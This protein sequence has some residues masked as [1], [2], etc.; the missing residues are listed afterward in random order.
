MAKKMGFSH[1]Q[2]EVLEADLRAM[3]TR[4]Q[5]LLIESSRGYGVSAELT[6]R[7]VRVIKYLSGVRSEADRLFTKAKNAGLTNKGEV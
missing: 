7:I 2:H 6:R 4:L 1:D 3:N 5:G